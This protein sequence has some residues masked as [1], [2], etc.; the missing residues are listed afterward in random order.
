MKAA[1]RLIRSFLRDRRAVSAIEF[2][3]VVPVLLVLYLGATDLADGLDV[4]KKVSR[5]ASVVADL[6]AR[7]FSIAPA[8]L[9]DMF[10]IGATTLLPYRRSQPH[11]RITAIQVQGTAAKNNLEPKVLWSRSNTAGMAD[12]AGDPADLPKALIAETAFYVRVDVELDYSPINA[13]VFKSLPMRETYFLA[14]RYT[15]SIPCASC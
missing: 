2:A 5:S 6:V 10:A 13:W 8:D 9:D 15:N 11:I 3:I 7:Q 12:N 4:N 14:P 1:L